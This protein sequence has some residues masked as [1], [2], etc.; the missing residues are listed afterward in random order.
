MDHPGSFVNAVM[1][2]S[3][4]DSPKKVLGGA[5]VESKD[6]RPEPACNRPL[7]QLL[8]SC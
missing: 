6:P 5:L 3:R 7:A 8:T 1:G 4:V 2:Q